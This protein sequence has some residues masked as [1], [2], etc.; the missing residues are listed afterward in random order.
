MATERREATALEL[1]VASL[2]RDNI[3]PSGTI[4]SP[5]HGV[6]R[7]LETFVAEGDE[8]LVLRSSGR[9]ETNTGKFLLVSDKWI[10]E[11][12]FAA[13]WGYGGRLC[14]TGSVVR[15]S[16]VVA[17]DFTPENFAYPRDSASDPELAP[18]VEVRFRDFSLT[19]GGE[20][21]YAFGLGE[22]SA[23]IE[24]SRLFALLS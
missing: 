6:A 5:I 21:D 13:G 1:A 23:A 24:L 18:A 19:V 11:V 14:L 3:D 20:G 9:T 2:Y 7:Y 10:G 22:D 15:R 4:V 12:D 17:V 8:F 16:D